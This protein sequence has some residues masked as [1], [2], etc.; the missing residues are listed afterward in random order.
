MIGITGFVNNIYLGEIYIINN[1]FPSK[2]HVYGLKDEKLLST[3]YK[4]KQPKCLCYELASNR[5]FVSDSEGI[6]IYL[7]GGGLDIKKLYYLKLN[8]NFRTITEKN[9]YLFCLNDKG[10]LS[11]IEIK[12]VQK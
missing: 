6:Y 10:V 8:E 9:G 5:L 12:P 7:I 1:Q 11:V 3:E 2:L 4:F